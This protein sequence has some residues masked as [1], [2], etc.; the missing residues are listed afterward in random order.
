M[1]PAA[2]AYLATTTPAQWAEM[3]K[4]MQRK[5]EQMLEERVLPDLAQRQEAS[6][7]RAR[8]WAKRLYGRLETGQE[9]QLERMVKQSP[10][11][12]A[13]WAQDRQERQ[14]AFMRWLQKGSTEHRT[15]QEWQQG[16]RPHWEAVWHS[17]QEGYRPLQAK[18]LQYQCDALAQFHNTTTTQ[19]R[20][21]AAEVLGEWRSLFHKLSAVGGG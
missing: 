7:K 12:V 5:H 4:R 18:V 9:A 21:H 10:F 6:L 17:S 15:A 16:L 14:K 8:Q 11:D 20:Q 2:A 3:D 13:R 19:Q 1:E